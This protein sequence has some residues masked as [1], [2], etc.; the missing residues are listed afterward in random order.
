MPLIT[1]LYSPGCNRACLNTFSKLSADSSWAAAGAPAR[2]SNSKPLNMI[3]GTR[4]QRPPRKGEKRKEPCLLPVRQEVC[5][6]KGA[7]PGNGGAGV[8]RRRAA[9]GHPAEGAP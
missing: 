5:A 4:M 9:I 1:H 2:H 3:L 7:R 6:G 8:P